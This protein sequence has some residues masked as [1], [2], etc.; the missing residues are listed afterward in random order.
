MSD[1]GG[2]VVGGEEVPL[3][4]MPE[5]PAETSGTF[6]EVKETVGR[7]LTATKDRLRELRKQREDINAEIKLLVDEEDLLMR[8]AKVKKK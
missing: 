4:G 2:D 5:V 7:A 1:E 3:P 8:M 6:D